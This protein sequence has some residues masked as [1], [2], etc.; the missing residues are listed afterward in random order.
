MNFFANALPSSLVTYEHRQQRA[1]SESV[2]PSRSNAVPD[3][4]IQAR[5]VQSD[6]E[7]KAAGDAEEADTDEAFA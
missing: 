2:E 7:Q 4:R 3:A 5:P 6:A 1:N